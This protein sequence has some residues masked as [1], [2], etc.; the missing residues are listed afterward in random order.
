MI[1]LMV[2]YRSAMRCMLS[3]CA[4]LARRH[5]VRPSV[6]VAAVTA[7]PR[8]GALPLCALLL[9]SSALTLHA[10][11]NMTP[12][13]DRN[14]VSTTGTGVRAHRTVAGMAGQNDNL[15]QKS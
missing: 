10:G 11:R 13:G 9:L 6:Q 3:C 1:L 8:S 2:W 4:R 14:N 5:P 7:M 15:K 12:A